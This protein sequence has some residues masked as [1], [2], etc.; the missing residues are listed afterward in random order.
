MATGATA[1]IGTLLFDDFS[2]PPSS[3]LWDYNHF[4]PVNNPSFYGRTQ[5][6][7]SLPAASGGLLHLELD[8]Y[9]PTALVPGDSFFGTEI[10]SNQTFSTAAGGIAFEASARI[11]TLA[12][13]IV[14]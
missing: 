7:Q 3:S 11:V 9:N 13:G 8:S 10:I 2:A 1:E 14:G 6:R 12:R 5:I 4:S